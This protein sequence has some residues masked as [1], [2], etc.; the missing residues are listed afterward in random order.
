MTPDATKTIKCTCCGKELPRTH[1]YFNWQNKSK[2]NLRTICRECYNAQKCKRGAEIKENEPEK[3]Q[4]ILQQHRDYYQSHKEQA[5]RNAREWRRK[6]KREVQDGFNRN[7]TRRMQ[8]DPIYAFCVKARRAVR[9]VVMN[10]GERENRSSKFIPVLTGLQTP[11]LHDYLLG[12]F[13]QIYG[14]EWDG[15][16]PTYVDHI[17]PLCTESTLEGKQKLFHYTNLRLVKEAD[18]RA[19][20]TSLDYQIGGAVC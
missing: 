12:T 6:H 15:V 19:K 14:Y 2:N 20:G 9:Y 5:N 17:I 16:D 3:Y 13:K 4:A 10:K 7:R 1:D 11:E 18:N 8:E